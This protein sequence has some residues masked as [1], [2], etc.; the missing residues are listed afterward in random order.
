MKLFSHTLLFCCLTLLRQTTSL[1]APE[2]T[3]D[4]PT[5]PTAYAA[6]RAV[7]KSLGDKSLERVVSVTGREGVPQPYLWRVTLSEPTGTREVDVAAGKIVAQRVATGKPAPVGG[8]LRAQELNLDSSGAFDAAEAQARKVRVRFDSLNY[9]LQ[10]GEGGKPSWSLELFNQDGNSIGKMRI[11]ATDGTV[12]AIDGRLAVAAPA[13]VA[14]TTT[15]TPRTSVGVNP[16]VVVERK[17]TT[18]AP[19]PVVVAPAGPV[20]PNTVTTTTTTTTTDTVAGPTDAPVVVEADEDNDSG[21]FTRAGRTLD[22][23]NHSVIRGV[24]QTNE[25]VKRSLRRTGATIQRFFVGHSDL[26]HPENR[27]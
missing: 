23:T 13:S 4:P 17:I 26:D 18:L 14:P 3:A 20:P 12:A 19:A 5:N 9:A 1:G 21:F 2:T 22:H 15:G 7:Q 27:E 25:T 16:P 6:I 10:I 11:A 8:A 24:D